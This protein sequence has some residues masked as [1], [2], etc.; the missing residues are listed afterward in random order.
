VSRLNPVEEGSGESSSL[1]ELFSE[2]QLHLEIEETP[3]ML[4]MLG[5]SPRTLKGLWAFMQ[6]VLTGQGSVSHTTKDLVA[7]AAASAA[8]ASHLRDWLRKSLEE[9]GIDSAMLSDLVEKGE[10]LR[11]PD[12][13][14]KILVF[15]RRAALDPAL[16]QDEDFEV[17]TKAGLCSEEI[18]ELVGFSGLVACLI[19]ITRALGLSNDP[20]KKK[21]TK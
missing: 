9:R 6:A 7:L 10:T 17:L 11:L 8:D 21:E 12:H 5:H 4:R 20:T 18:A 19:S 3:T 14:R 13:T 15:T 1:K 2:I 16:L